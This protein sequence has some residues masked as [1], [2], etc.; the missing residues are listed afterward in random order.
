MLPTKVSLAVLCL[1]V[2]AATIVV[3]DLFTNQESARKQ[4][5]SQ[6]SAQSQ[7]NITQEEAFKNALNL[8]IQKNNEGV[9][10]T[11]GPCLGTIAPDWVLDIAHNPRLPIDDQPENQCEELRAGRAHHFVELTPEGNII[12][13][14]Q[15]TP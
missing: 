7:Q 4:Q 12:R 3:L 2:I 11:K 5:A 14:D 6:E 13:I 8:Y 1:L 15:R 10:F 9:D